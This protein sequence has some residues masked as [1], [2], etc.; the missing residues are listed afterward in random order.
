M[1]GENRIVI[2]I[3]DERTVSHG[4][5]FGLSASQMEMLAND[6]ERLVRTVT[7][8]PISR[9]GRKRTDDRTRG[10]GTRHLHGRT[11]RVLRMA[12]EATA[13]DAV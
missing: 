13:A 2:V 3:T 4:C 5:G 6:V 7:G 12:G 11:G 9:K 10:H 8:A 1:A